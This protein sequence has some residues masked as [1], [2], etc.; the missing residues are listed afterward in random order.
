MLLFFVVLGLTAVMPT[1]TIVWVG[2]C[3]LRG[4]PRELPVLGRWARRVVDD[5]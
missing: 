4:Q 2:F 5:L 3:A 1:A